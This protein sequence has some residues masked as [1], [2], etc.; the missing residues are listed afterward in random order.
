MAFLGTLV[1]LGGNNSLFQGLL[2]ST[3][4]TFTFQKFFKARF[5]FFFHYDI[6]Y[7]RLLFYSG[8]K[9]YPPKSKFFVR[10]GVKAEEKKWFLLQ[11]SFL[12]RQVI[13]SLKEWASPFGAPC[14]HTWHSPKP[15]STFLPLFF[16][17]E[18]RLGSFHETVKPRSYFIFPH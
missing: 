3:I 4:I 15:I 14:N 9:T 12:G 5:M 10:E 7:H 6:Q 16:E 11:R 17:Q 1:Y 8:F 13:I 18:R 2:M